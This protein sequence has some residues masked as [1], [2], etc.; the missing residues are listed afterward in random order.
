MSV[1]LGWMPGAATQA[2]LADLQHRIRAALPADAPRHDWRTPAQWHMTL[3]YLGES[4]DDARRMR[5]DDALQ[6]LASRTQA[7]DAIL[8]GAQY[9]P[10]ARVLVAKVEAT[11]ALKA[12]LKQLEMAMQG[13]GFAKERTQTA[14]ITLAYLPRGAQ[15]PTLPDMAIPASP[16]R[17][18][19]IE[20]LQTVPAGYMSL[21]SWPFAPG[22]TPA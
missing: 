7:I 9:W 10:H 14:H 15:P 16:L 17:V 22:T 4:I 19:R 6:V 2:A 5:I 21:A 18:D 1:F 20:L 13:C 11:E 3:R 12:L 8:A